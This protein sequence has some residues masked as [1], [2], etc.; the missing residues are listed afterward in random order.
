MKNTALLYYSHSSA[1]SN[2]SAELTLLY[3]LRDQPQ[4]KL[5]EL[6]IDLKE[7]KRKIRDLETKKKQDF[8]TKTRPHSASP[9][10]RNDSLS[11]IFEKAQV[12]YKNGEI[13]AAE[14]NLLHILKVV[15]G[16]GPTSNNRS[17]QSRPKS[18]RPSRNSGYVKAGD[19]SDFDSEVGDV[20]D[21]Q[22]GYADDFIDS[23][24]IDVNEGIYHK[25]LVIESGADSELQTAIG[26]ADEKT[27]ISIL[28]KPSIRLMHNDAPNSLINERMT[29]S[30]ASSL[31]ASLY[32][33]SGSVIRRSDDGDSFDERS[34]E[35]I[36][37]PDNKPKDNVTS[38]K[39]LQQGPISDD[40]KE[41]II[42]YDTEFYGEVKQPQTGQVSDIRR[43]SEVL[44]AEHHPKIK[45]GTTAKKEQ[46]SSKVELVTDSASNKNLELGKLVDAG[47]Y[48]E[49]PKLTSAFSNDLMNVTSSPS[50]TEVHTPKLHIKPRKVSIVE[51]LKNSVSS[52]TKRNQKG[53]SGSKQILSKEEKI[54]LSPKTQS[55][56][57]LEI[58]IH[59][60]DVDLL[61][62]NTNANSMFEVPT[63]NLKDELLIQNANAN[64]MS[65]DPTV[66][67]KEEILIRNTNANSMVVIPTDCLKDEPVIQN[68]N[69]NN[70]SGLS[71]SLDNDECQQQMTGGTESNKESCGPIL[72]T[73]YTVDVQ[74]PDCTN[75]QLPQILPNLDKKTSSRS[76][77]KLT[78]ERSKDS[79]KKHN[80][81]KSRKTGPRNGPG[82]ISKN[83]T[84]HL[85]VKKVHVGAPF[86]SVKTIK[87]AVGG[88]S[89][90]PRSKITKKDTNIRHDES[91]PNG[92]KFH[93]IDRLVG[94]N[95]QEVANELE[96]S[97]EQ[98]SHVEDSDNFKAASYERSSQ[99]NAS[100]S[101]TSNDSIGAKKCNDGHEN[102]NQE[103]AGLPTTSNDSI[104]VKESK[105]HEILDQESAGL[106]NDKIKAKKS[107]ENL[108]EFASQDKL[109]ITGL[110][111]AT[112]Y[113]QPVMDDIPK[114]IRNQSTI[115]HENLL[116]NVK[117]SSKPN[118]SDK[119]SSE[120]FKEVHS[121]LVASSELKNKSF[122]INQTQRS[123][124]SIEPELDMLAKEIVRIRSFRSSLKQK[125]MNEIQEN[126]EE[127]S[128]SL[129][130]KA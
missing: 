111:V 70:V 99:E 112:A 64:S 96:P 16:Q 68:T 10:Y 102:L 116:T 87:T 89:T 69:H 42:G 53:Y 108:E 88:K 104:T 22:K 26:N 85:Q 54:N 97:G 57:N 25:N 72:P 17:R 21:S 44:K 106:Q 29:S 77:E 100:L 128:K 93:R 30:S 124:L 115:S 49:S 24:P 123:T 8:V 27:T 63:I 86:N 103:S 73:E 55:T 110:I 50:Q 6:G 61:V 84:S 32:V 5:E 13:K 51:A 107:N 38:G 39:I 60:T 118:L 80:I 14:L 114:D 65:E 19:F 129:Q 62:Q 48:C 43:P 4:E 1:K 121:T 79:F 90:A 105:S 34:I 66:N 126:D 7:V 58:K 125:V 122:D 94:I 36:F 35:L 41:F 20:K 28:E 83:V 47:N 56:P 109:K 71:Q 82:I 119:K 40:P 95:K 120:S 91:V 117:I 98:S 52:L 3:R 33:R 67:F 31:S 15:Q 23:P 18:A 127:I 101:K 81:N 75:K 45:W 76:E 130:I 12:A 92:S 11:S 113:D 37:Q 46:T 2:T 9:T 74:R 59:M 78:G